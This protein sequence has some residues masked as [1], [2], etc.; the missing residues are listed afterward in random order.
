MNTAELSAR[1]R[2][3][4]EGKIVRTMA[5]SVS[6]VLIEVNSVRIVPVTGVKDGSSIGVDVD[7]DT[8][9]EGSTPDMVG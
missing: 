1:I 7:G 3:E 6:E 2:G 8:T 4:D 5:D 9:G